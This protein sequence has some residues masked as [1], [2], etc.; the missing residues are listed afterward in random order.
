MG[1][2]IKVE[3]VT[4]KNF[5]TVK[6]RDGEMWFAND[7]DLQ[8]IFLGY[9]AK[10][11]NKYNVVIYGIAIEGNHYHILAH[12]PEGNR[13]SFMRALGSRIAKTIKKKRGEVR[14]G[15]VFESRYDCRYLVDDSS[16]QD[17]F[18]YTVLQPVQ[19]GLVKRIE[20]YP[21]YNCFYDAVNCETIQY[22]VFN[23]TEYYRASR[24]G[25]KVNPADFYDD[26]YLEFS[27]LPGYENLSDEEYRKLMKKLL[28]EY[29][30]RAV[31]KREAKGKKGFVGKERLK[32]VKP[33]TPA[34]SVKVTEPKGVEA[35][36][37]CND[38]KLKREVVEWYKGVRENHRTKSLQYI[39]GKVDVTFPPG[40]YKPPV[41]TSKGYFP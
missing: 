4:F 23:G 5:L 40:T 24:W 41:W 19:D 38:K 10:Y 12:F 14:K 29:T 28:D 31:E 37:L 8:E 33:G 25:A 6:L 21:G 36:F 34:K 7:R 17:K 13:A 3:T 1:H 2:P 11:Q 35:L 20:D 16:V 22:W 39:K 27:R 18:F 26:Y 15:S 9:V 30:Q 32:E